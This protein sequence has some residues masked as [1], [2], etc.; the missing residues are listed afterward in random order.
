MRLVWITTAVLCACGGRP[1]PITTAE[2]HEP[3]PCDPM[4]ENLDRVLGA[5]YTLDLEDTGPVTRDRLAMRCAHLTASNRA[6]FRFAAS[7]DEA[8]RCGPGHE[9]SPRTYEGATPAERDAFDACADAATTR[10]ELAR[11]AY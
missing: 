6:C 5:G 8:S 3:T 4:L 9:P 10:A 1:S 7:R 2:P 11:C